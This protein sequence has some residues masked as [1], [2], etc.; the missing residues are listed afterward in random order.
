MYKFFISPNPSTMPLMQNIFSI[1]V[2]KINIL[3]PAGYTFQNNL[4]TLFN[5]LIKWS[6]S[7]FKTNLSESPMNKN[8]FESTLDKL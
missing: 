4:G 6:Q 8:K 1:I 2:K 3:I 7:D 5:L